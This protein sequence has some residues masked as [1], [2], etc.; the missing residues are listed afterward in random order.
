M[1]SENVHLME[2]SFHPKYRNFYFILIPIVY[3]I[4]TPFEEIEEW[5]QCSATCGE[6][7]ESQI[8]LRTCIQRGLQDVLQICNGSVI[9]KD[10]RPCNVMECA[11]GVT[12]F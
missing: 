8:K 12:R 9:Q 6:G 2:L 3:G 7:I 11:S 4:W 5:S 1:S 10:T